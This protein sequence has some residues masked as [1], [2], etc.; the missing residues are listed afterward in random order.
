MIVGSTSVLPPCYEKG[1]YWKQ[2]LHSV[3]GSLAWN[4]VARFAQDTTQA[5]KLYTLYQSGVYP[6]EYT[7]DYE[8]ESEDETADDN[9]NMP[10]TIEHTWRGDTVNIGHMTRVGLPHI[11]NPGQMMADSYT[12]NVQVAK[13]RVTDGASKLADGLDSK[14]MVRKKTFVDGLDGALAV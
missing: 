3:E 1:V 2:Y 4:R 9:G 14:E 5:R 12:G 10:F 11:E 8:G 6:A 7:T 13:Q